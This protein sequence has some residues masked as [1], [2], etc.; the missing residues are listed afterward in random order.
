YVIALLAG[1][2]SPDTTWGSYI[3]RGPD[4]RQRY[5][6][7]FPPLSELVNEANRA[8]LKKRCESAGDSAERAG[9]EPAVGF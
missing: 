4:L 9:F 6:E 3:K 2:K 8:K 7:P 5:G 1:H